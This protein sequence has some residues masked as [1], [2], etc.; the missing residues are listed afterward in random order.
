VCGTGSSCSATVTP[1]YAGSNYVAFVS[2]SS[3]ALP[4]GSIVASSN[5]VLV[6]RLPVPTAPIHGAAGAASPPASVPGGAKPV[7]QAP[8]APVAPVVVPKPGAGR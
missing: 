8:R 7:P 6:T 5:V 2:D 4:P 3:S 1:S